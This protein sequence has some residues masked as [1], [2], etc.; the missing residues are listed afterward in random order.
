VLNALRSLGIAAERMTAAGF[1]ES[2]PKVPNDT[3][4]R[5]AVNRRVEFIVEQGS[6]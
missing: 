4:A 1:G 2:R 3:A 5:R 6:G